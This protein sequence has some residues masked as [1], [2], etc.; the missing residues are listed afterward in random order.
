MLRQQGTFVQQLYELHKLNQVQKLLMCELEIS[1]DEVPMVAPEPSPAI[2]PHKRLSHLRRCIRCLHNL[3]RMVRQSGCQEQEEDEQGR[4][5]G[6]G[7]G[8]GQDSRDEEVAR[9]KFVSL[10]PFVIRP[11]AV[12]LLPP[13]AILDMARPAQSLQPTVQQKP[14]SR[15]GCLLVVDGDGSDEGS[16]SDDKQ[17]S[18]R[19]A[20]A[21][22]GRGVSKAL[23]TDGRLSVQDASDVVMQEA[24]PQVNK[25]GSIPSR[26]MIESRNSCTPMD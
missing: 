13:D 16:G 18:R 19:V 15:G 26:L 4:E 2:D 3:P 10:P 20:L 7:A 23:A 22:A 8:A 21:V 1:V 24:L 25:R 6:M 9:A 17:Q 11:L 12:Y 14:P 5:Q